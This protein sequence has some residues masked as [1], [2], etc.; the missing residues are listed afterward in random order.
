MIEIS[1]CARECN[2]RT[3]P[4]V[5]KDIFWNS[6]LTTNVTLKN[7]TY[8]EEVELERGEHWNEED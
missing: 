6:L 3:N 2:N 1:G 8:A 4:D 5:V 7:M